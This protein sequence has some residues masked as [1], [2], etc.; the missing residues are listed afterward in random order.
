[1]S[2]SNN[3]KVFYIFVQWL[4]TS[5]TTTPQ[6]SEHVG[7]AL[8]TSASVDINEAKGV[9]DTLT[10]YACHV[11]PGELLQAYHFLLT[12]SVRHLYYTQTLLS[13][14]HL[15]KTSKAELYTLSVWSLPSFLWRSW[16]SYTTTVCEELNWLT[17]V[18]NQMKPK[19]LLYSYCWFALHV[20]LPNSSC[21]VHM[22]R[23]RAVKSKLA[24][25]L[26]CSLTRPTVESVTTTFYLT[27]RFATCYVDEALDNILEK[28]L[29]K[30]IE[31]QVW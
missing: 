15:P 2:N 20:P 22:L 6:V 1:M 7:L 29:A 5:I 24:R 9:V 23:R 21:T 18:G 3:N 19:T 26:S 16:E 8:L 25:T 31:R 27:L 13:Y 14:H 28:R 10:R 12:T 11:L 4:T 30:T 17:Y